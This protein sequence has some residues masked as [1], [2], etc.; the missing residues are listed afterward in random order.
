M[1]WV[2]ARR[3]LTGALRSI[4]RFRHLHPLPNDRLVFFHLLGAVVD[5]INE[6]AA[7]VVF[8]IARAR[9][10]GFRYDQSAICSRLRQCHIQGFVQPLALSY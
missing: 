8:F 9:Y 6:I 4:P 10:G 1:A 2:K 5:R 3:D 7:A